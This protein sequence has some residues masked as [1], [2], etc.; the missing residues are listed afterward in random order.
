MATSKASVPNTGFTILKKLPAG[1]VV[2]YYDDGLRAAWLV[3]AEEEQTTLASIP[4][5]KAQSRNFKIPTADIKLATD[6]T[7]Q[8]D[9][10]YLQAIKSKETTM[11]NTKKETRKA[12]T[13]T[14]GNGANGTSTRTPVQYAVVTAKLTKEVK[15][16]MKTKNTHFYITLRTLHTLKKATLDELVKAVIKTK[17]YSTTKGN[18]AAYIAG[19]LRDL[20]GSKLVEIN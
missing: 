15:E 17:L 10:R 8:P 3:K 4:P 11:A 5:H 2:Q 12:T 19:D 14:N 6:K 20:T 9:A 13:T 18:E 16:A 7:A 1:T